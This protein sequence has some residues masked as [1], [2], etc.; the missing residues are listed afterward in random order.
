MKSHSLYYQVDSSR[1]TAIFLTHGMYIHMCVCLCVYVFA[2]LDITSRKIQTLTLQLLMFYRGSLGSSPKVTD[3]ELLHLLLLPSLEKRQYLLKCARPINLTGN[4][5]SQQ[6]REESRVRASP[7]VSPG[8]SKK[9]CLHIKTADPMAPK[10]S[11]MF[12]VLYRACGESPSK[13]KTSVPSPDNGILFWR[14]GFQLATRVTVD[15]R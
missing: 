9:L 6:L 7:P 4:W 3:K 2:R 11:E 15:T 10:T 1:N 14:N 8:F 12:G 5:K 13:W